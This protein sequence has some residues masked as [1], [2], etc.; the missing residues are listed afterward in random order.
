[1]WCLFIKD[2]EKR[3]LCALQTREKKGCS[4]KQYYLQIDS[5]YVTLFSL[6][7]FYKMVCFTFV[8]L[9]ALAQQ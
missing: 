6:G 1:M 2:N 5:L 4:V 9:N 7:E 8:I 3:L